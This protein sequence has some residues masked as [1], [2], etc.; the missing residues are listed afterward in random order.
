MRDPQY[1][2]R[3]GRAEAAAMNAAYLAALMPLTV[4]LRHVIPAPY[5]TRQYPDAVAGVLACIGA[6]PVMLMMRG[7]MRRLP[8]EDDDDRRG[9]RRLTKELAAALAVGYATLTATGGLLA[10]FAIDLLLAG[11]TVGPTYAYV[12]G[13]SACVGVAILVGVRSFTRFRNAA[14]GTP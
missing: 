6:L 5:L 4:L 8:A 9:G 1:L 12:L 13:S 3:K 14:R 2:Q 10:V 7:L 11:Q